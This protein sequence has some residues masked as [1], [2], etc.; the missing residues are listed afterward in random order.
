MIRR[1]TPTNRLIKR[2]VLR[3]VAPYS[4]LSLVFLTAVLYAQQTAKFADLLLRAQLPSALAASVLLN[5]LPNAL[6]FAVPMA[7]LT[8]ILIGFSRMG[9]DSELVAMRAA[10]VSAWVIARPVMLMGLV[11]TLAM[12]YIN[13]ELGPR[14]ARYL[15]KTGLLAALNKLESPVE[16]HVFYT[17]I[18]DKVIYVRDGDK[19]KG[20]WGRVFI[21]SREPDGQV[22]VLTARSGRIDSSTDR[23]ELVLNNAVATTLPDGPVPD[24]GAPVTE[25][26]VQ[27]RVR[28]ESLEAGRNALQSLIRNDTAE[29][30]EMGW[31]ELIAARSA[32]EDAATRTDAAVM[33]YR[34]LSLA[35]APLVFAL[36]GAGL[37]LRVRRGGRGLGMA[38]SIAVMV[39]YYLLSLLGEQLSRTGVVPPAVGGWI[40]TSCVG[41]CGLLLLVSNHHG[42][43][44][45]RGRKGRRAPAPGTSCALSTRRSS[46]APGSRW[47][48]PGFPRLLDR[49][50]FWSLATGFTLAFTAL[51]AIFLIFTL[52]ELWRFIA[53]TGAG[54]RLVIRYLIYL[55]PLTTVSLAASGTLVAVLAAYTLMSRRSEVMAWWGCGQ[56]TYRLALPGLLFAAAVGLGLWLVQEQVM[57]EANRRQDALRAQIRGGVS[58]ATAPSGRQWLASADGRRI[59]SYEYDERSGTLRDP[60]IFEFGSDGVHIEKITGGETGRWVSHDQLEVTNRGR[61]WMVAAEPQAAFKP[62]LNKPSQLSA[63]ALSAYISNLRDRGVDVA[64]LAVALEK[65][66]SEPFVPLVMALVGVPLAFAF[67]RKSA[68]AALAAAVVVGVI[69]WGASSL[70]QQAASYGLMAPKVAAWAPPGIFAALGMLFLS[71]AP[72]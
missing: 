14:A 41:S 44:F 37:G 47:F 33:L 36:L 64:D 53:A 43:A 19:A 71:R 29:I 49:D 18:K 45:R 7:T 57:P 48:L 65:K 21:Q 30:D 62:A 23:A 15:R 46:L 24:G 56:S 50:V 42:F 22:R 1:A 12:A 72:T 67:G 54:A 63:K 5:I 31:D 28:L 2:Y 68:V 20:Q 6:V 59:Y 3:A 4:A 27:A 52:F 38:L 17:D 8:G 32:T 58:R 35:I 40:A 39:L 55:L 9:S 70:L 26:L 60:L 25:R 11:A 16:P 34:R 66:R 10:G 69:F 13:L 51:T 61:I